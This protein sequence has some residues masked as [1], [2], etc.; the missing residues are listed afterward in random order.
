MG[1]D[2][3]VLSMSPD[4]VR[5]EAEALLKPGPE[6]HWSRLAMLVGRVDDERLYEAWGYA[7]GPAWAEEDLG[8]AKREYVALVKSWRLIQK[9]LQ[10]PAE[11]QVGAEEWA[12]VSKAKAGLIAKVAGLGAPLRPWVDLAVSDITT[13]QMREAIEKHLGMEPWTT[14]TVALPTALAEVFES[15]LVLALP[16][17]TGEA[18]PDADSAKARDT[19]FRCLEVI[20]SGYIGSVAGVGS[21]GQS[22]APTPAPE[23]EPAVAAAIG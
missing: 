23:P 18:D 6:R 12:G 3:N 9:G 8:L 13:A 1:S 10:G 7:S 16:E 22:K 14:V 2:D 20:L 5:V 17:A 11:G 19:R 21:S 15:A 4:E